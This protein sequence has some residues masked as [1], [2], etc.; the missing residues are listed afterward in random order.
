M[1]V[2]YK[3]QWMA[4]LPMLCL[5]QAVDIQEQCTTMQDMEIHYMDRKDLS[6]VVTVV[7]FQVQPAMMK[8]STLHQHLTWQLMLVWMM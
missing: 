5:N 2:K 1:V 6:T 3:F 8:I 7:E 4:E